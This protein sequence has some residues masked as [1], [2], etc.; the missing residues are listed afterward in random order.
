[1]VPIDQTN[2]SYIFPGLA[3]GVV[4][5]QAR[6]ISDEMIKAAAL[7]LADLS[8]ASS[9]LPPLEDIRSVSRKVAGAVGRKAMQQGLSDLDEAQ[10]ETALEAN[11]WEPVYVPY[12]LEE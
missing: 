5:S 9:L 2:N 8:P 1:M 4:S 3:L 11:I 6:R 12:E 7:A 10:F